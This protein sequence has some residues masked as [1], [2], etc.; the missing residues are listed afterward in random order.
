MNCCTRWSA[1]TAPPCRAELLRLPA[2]CCTASSAASRCDLFLT[3]AAALDQAH[4]Q[5]EFV[6]ARLDL[7]RTSIGVAITRRA[8]ADV[9]TPE[10]LE[11]ALL[12]A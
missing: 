10:A 2:H 11:R 12:A 9:S 6:G 4:Q 8:E 5:A 1:P 3:D 7:C